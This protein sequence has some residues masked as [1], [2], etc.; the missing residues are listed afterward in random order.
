MNSAQPKSTTGNVRGEASQA[1][2]DLEVASLVSPAGIP[3]NPWTTWDNVS[4]PKAATKAAAGKMGK[5]Y[6]ALRFS[7]KV[8]KRVKQS[9]NNNSQPITFSALPHPAASRHGRRTAPAAIARPKPTS[10]NGLSLK[11]PLTR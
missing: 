3:A 9:I 11:A 2:S 1:G 4:Q 5:R 6:R 10:T 8:I 7:P